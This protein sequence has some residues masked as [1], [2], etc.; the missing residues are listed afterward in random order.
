MP[1]HRAT[2]EQRAVWAALE[3]RR[4]YTLDDI[5]LITDVPP[6]ESL[7]YLGVLMAN[8]YVRFA[9]LKFADSGEA[10]PIFQLVQRTG[11]EA[12]FVGS[13]G[14]FV[15]PQRAQAE[16]AARAQRMGLATMPTLRARMRVAAMRRGEPF[17]KA[18]LREALGVGRDDRLTF[19]RAWDQCVFKGEFANTQAT[20]SPARYRYYPRNEEA[21]RIR[22]FLKRRPGETMTAM[23]LKRALGV[24]FIPSSEIRHALDML[25]A[26][27]WGIVIERNTYKPA[28]YRVERPAGDADAAEY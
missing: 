13:D 6:A 21:E 27:G 2:P 26:E 4:P 10:L 18:D 9:G 16:E 1:E 8:S 24:S 3:S 23:D 22:L 14:V 28:E 11:T 5:G 15:D 12:P 25:A 19:T 17:T 20:G 7:P